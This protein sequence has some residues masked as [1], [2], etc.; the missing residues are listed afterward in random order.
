MR[1]IIL[2]SAFALLFILVS[3]NVFA[4]S[5]GHDSLLF[6]GAGEV[7]DKMI[8]KSCWK[9]KHI[10]GTVRGTKDTL[11]KYEYACGFKKKEGV[12]FVTR[13][14]RGSLKEE[15]VLYEDDLIELEEGSI[16][17]MELT[18]VRHHLILTA[19]GVENFKV[20]SC[21]KNNFKWEKVKTGKYFWESTDW[22]LQYMETPSGKY[23]NLGTKYSLETSDNED[24]L[25]VYEG[26]VEVQ[27]KHYRSIA[28]EES[29]KLT[30]AF[31]SGKLS[32]EEYSAKMKELAPEIKK[33]SEKVSKKIIVD[34]GYQITVGIDGL[35]SEII[36][37][38]SDD[39]K[40]WEK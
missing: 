34:A 29:K 13:Q 26:S 9:V 37:I 32:M 40:W 17:Q 5:G 1:K 10:W 27:P 31:Q 14:I 18:D 21:D 3:P 4:F 12:E 23:I 36:P 19:T 38:P 30:E 22:N 6:D 39:L 28:L 25:K 11:V 16:I 33:E 24:I 35:F 8:E 2:K 20:P 7:F 15:M